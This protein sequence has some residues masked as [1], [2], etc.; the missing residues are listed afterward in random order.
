LVGYSVEFSKTTTADSSVRLWVDDGAGQTTTLTGYYFLDDGVGYAT[1]AGAHITAADPTYAGFFKGFLYSL[2]IYNTETTTGSPQ[3]PTAA[4]NAVCTD[5][6][7]TCTADLTDCLADWEFS[8]YAAGSPCKASCTNGCVRDEECFAVTCDGGFLFCDLCFDRECTVCTGYKDGNCTNGKCLGST[9]NATGDGSCTCKPEF[10]RSDENFLC[11]ACHANCKTCE[12]NGEAHYENCTDCNSGIYVAHGTV[13]YCLDECPT[14]YDSGA[15]APT[16]T[17]PTTLATQMIL[18]YDFNKPLKNWTNAGN[19]TGTFDLTTTTDYPSGHPARNR[20][21]YFGGTNKTAYIPITGLKLSHTCAV[22]TWALFQTD[23][24][25]M[26]VFSKDR[27]A[28]A[29]TQP[30]VVALTVTTAKR[31]KAEM[32]KDLTT[33]A[34]D[35]VTSDTDLSVNTWYYLVYS[36]TMESGK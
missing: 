14:G 29:P 23:T 33:Y 19:L 6:G 1:T 11:A 31:M 2:Y 9:T 27:G 3:Y 21:V 24:A 15:G 17:A 28:F 22:H 12:G 13:K 35:S 7:M 18:S 26:T 20:G 36:F 32:S 4:C 34:L 16:C 25:E 10:G 30:L 8:E 5:A